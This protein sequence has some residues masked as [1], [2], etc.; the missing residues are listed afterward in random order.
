MR[1]SPSCF[2][3]KENQSHFKSAR[4]PTRSSLAG[5]RLPVTGPQ[6]IEN[7]QLRA[8]VKS[9][10]QLKCRALAPIASALAT[11]SS[12]D[13]RRRRSSRRQRAWRSLAPARSSRLVFYD[14]GQGKGVHGAAGQWQ[15]V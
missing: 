9:S 4:D 1:H 13:R 10:I 3:N 2:H 5:P 11:V 8:A 14:H 7:K 12:V 6:T 15:S